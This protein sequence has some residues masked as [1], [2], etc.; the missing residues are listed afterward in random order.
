MKE[1]ALGDRSLFPDLRA[2]AYLNH[3]AISPPS[4]PVREAVGARLAHAARLGV[5]GF[6][7]AMEQSDRLRERLARVVGAPRPDDVAF[8]A[9]TTAGLT[10]VALCVPWAPGDR[11][12]LTRGEF[13]ANVTP[14]QRAA[15]LFGLEIAW[16][17][18][19]RADGM[20]EWLAGLAAEL[21]RGARMV[22]VSAVQFQTGLRMPLERIGA[23]C[24]QAGAELCVDAIQACGVVPLDVERMQIDYLSCGSHKWLMGPEGLAFLYVAPDRA[25]ALRPH[26]AGW[27]SHQDAFRFLFE[28]RGHLRYDRPLQ[29]TAKMVEG[30][31]AN[32]IG[33]AGLAASV[34]ILETLGIEAIFDH[35]DGYLGALEPELEA[36]GFSSLRAEDRALRSGILCVDPPSGVDVV[37]LHEAIEPARVSCAIPDGWLRFAPH[38]PNHAR[39]IP[40]VVEAIDEALAKVRP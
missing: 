7:E 17:P 29:P 4:Q 21:S 35:V 16:L 2:E 25:A 19:P 8:V 1:P 5:G 15:E 26:V 18:T 31:M 39:E 33:Q 30:G 32:V 28:G 14:W 22:A 6:S 27:T 23:A 9:N 37:A 36:R 20:D 11:L 38:W 12:L 40:G 13:P 24:H 3:A 34:A 10:D